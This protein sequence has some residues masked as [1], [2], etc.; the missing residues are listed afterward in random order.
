MPQCVAEQVAVAGLAAQLDSSR[1]VGR[2]RGVTVER[3]LPKMTSR[4]DREVAAVRSLD[5]GEE[6]EGLHRERLAGFRHADPSERLA[7]VRVREAGKFRGRGPNDGLRHAEDDVGPHQ[8]QDPVE[9]VGPVDHVQEGL[10]VPHDVP[11][12]HERVGVVR[13]RVALHPGV[14]AARH[15]RRGLPS[16]LMPDRVD[17]PAVQR[18]FAGTQCSLQVD[19]TVYRPLAALLIGQGRHSRALLRIRARDPTSGYSILL[20]V[21]HRLSCIVRCGHRPARVRAPRPQQRAARRSTQRTPRARPK[22]GP[23]R[24]HK[25]VSSPHGAETEPGQSASSSVSQY[26]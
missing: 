17:Q 11:P 22:P 6:I 25:D 8:L 5:I 3:D 21:A 2:G 26:R 20:A 13:G 24:R 1:R 16:R 14:M 19:V 10:R 4:E 12:V 23:P 15:V 9:H 18:N 7:S